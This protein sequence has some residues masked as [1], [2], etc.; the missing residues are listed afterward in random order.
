MSN[1]PKVNKA[2]LTWLLTGCFLVAAM[3]IIGGITRLTHS[4]LS[5]VNWKPVTG[6]LP[7][8]NDQQWQESFEAYQESPEFKKVN[9]HF[10]IEEYKAI[11]WWEYIHRLLGRII[12]VV[13]L[14]PFLIFL[15]KKQIDKN[16]LKKLI[17]NMKR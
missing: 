13:F 10:D 14:I 12:G 11:F 4:G 7:P 16:L 9:H 3:V 17:S 8:L 15:L 5:M 1:I 6:V 2:I